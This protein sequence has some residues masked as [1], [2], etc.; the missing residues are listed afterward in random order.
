MGWVVC[1]T[2]QEPIA[3][4]IRRSLHATHIPLSSL[5]ASV[6]SE[7][8]RS[9]VQRIAPSVILLEVAPNLSNAH[10][11]IFLRSD[12]TTRHTPIIALSTDRS[13]TPMIMAL[14][15]DSVLDLYTSPDIIAQ[16]VTQ[17]LPQ[18]VALEIGTIPVAR[19]TLPK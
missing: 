14:G 17:F 16:A 1:F 18:P 11:L 6:L 2:D 19:A 15:A 13:A 9:S 8:V 4:G 10:L 5:P 3:S 12:S 7:E